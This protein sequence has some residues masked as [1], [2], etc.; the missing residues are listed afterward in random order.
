[1]MRTVLISLAAMTACAGVLSCQSSQ[2]RELEAAVR[3][4]CVDEDSPPDNPTYDE[5]CMREVREQILT[6]RAY[7]PSTKPPRKN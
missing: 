7:R 2:S 6:A 5:T 4:A 1:M 3:A